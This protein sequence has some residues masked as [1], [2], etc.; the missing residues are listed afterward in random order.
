MPLTGAAFAQSVDPLVEEAAYYLAN[1]HVKE[2]DLKALPKTS[3]DELLKAVDDPYVEYM[4]PQKFQRFTESLDGSFGGV[5]IQ[6]EKRGDYITVIAP[7]KNTP[8][9]QAGLKPGDRIL[10]VDG[11][12]LVGASTETAISLIRGKP[13]TKVTLT[14]DRE[15]E[16]F[17]VTL[18]RALI[19]IRGTEWK[20]LEDSVGYLR[21][22]TFGKSTPAEVDQALAE[23][24]NQGIKSL[25]VDLRSNPGGLL[26]AVIEIAGNFLPQ[27]APVVHVRGRDGQESFPAKGKGIAIPLVVLVDGGSA[28]GSEI[29]AGAIQ[30]YNLGAIVG[31]NTFGKGSVQTLFEL[32]NG[33]VLK[34]TTA[35]YVTPVGRLIEGVG[36][37]PEHQV[38]GAD[39]QL[40]YA[41]GLLGRGRSR[42]VV[43]TIAGKEAEVAG[44]KVALETPPFIRQDRAFVPLR[45]VSESLGAVVNWEQ[46]SQKATIFLGTD[47]ITLAPGRQTALVNGKEKTMDVSSILEKGR[48]YVPIRF[49]AEV[50]G[51]KV[52][53]DGLLSQVRITR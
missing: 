27:G 48:I 30:D 20:V 16:V 51:S 44:R 3:M 1:F 5:G 21:L 22:A 12:S 28:S 6:I 26:A 37:L 24:T 38:A 23:L 45:F 36:L 40:A 25:I 32:S 9:Y 43:L 42:Q 14:L 29:L 50:L 52:E 39:N 4:E 7:V 34:M 31:T 8:A 47:K 13:G 18:E 49:V 19:K 53:W 41:L 33:G 2:L 46:E 17:Q 15:G 35:K 11:N 10:A